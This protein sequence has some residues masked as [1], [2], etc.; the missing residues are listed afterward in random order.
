L[1]ASHQAAAQ[2][3]AINSRMTTVINTFMMILIP[4]GPSSAPCQGR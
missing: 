2:S 1:V 4:P 3:M